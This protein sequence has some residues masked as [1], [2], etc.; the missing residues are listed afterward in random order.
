MSYE[1]LSSK[2]E[3]RNYENNIIKIFKGYVNDHFV[4]KLDTSIQYKSQFADGVLWG[5]IQGIKEVLFLNI[6]K[7][8]DE[9]IRKKLKEDLKKKIVGIELGAF[10][11]D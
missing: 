10:L 3:F 4:K 7:I 11:N 9:D 1:I 2:E 6:N 5:R 8:K